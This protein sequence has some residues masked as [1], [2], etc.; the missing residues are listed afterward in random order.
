MRNILAILLLTSS[1]SGCAEEEV[2][3]DKSWYMNNVEA[4]EVKVKEC[5]NDA[6]IMDTP[7]C[8]NALNAKSTLAIKEM[9]N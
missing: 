7:N 6:S 5:N 2:V 8:K 4:M 9:F 1:V 3:R